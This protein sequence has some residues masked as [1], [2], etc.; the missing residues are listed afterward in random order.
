MNGGCRVWLA[1]EADAE[2]VWRLL[3]EFRDWMAKAEPI[4]DSIRATVEALVRDEATDFLL[5]EPHDGDGAAGVCQLRFRLSVW[6][7][8]P[9]CW[10]EDLYVEQGARR[11]GLGAALGRAAIERARTRGCRRIELD[12]NEDNAAALA[13]YRELGFSI[14]PK[15]PG[16]TLF[17]GREIEPA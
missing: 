14:E 8:A 2:A 1:G 17:M 15:P 5:V 16:R 3:A 13:L 10:L 7:A 12:V 6:T 11:A 9:D 4:D